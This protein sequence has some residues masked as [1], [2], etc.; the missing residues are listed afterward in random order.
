MRHK[1][2]VAAFLLLCAGS[3]FALTGFGESNT[4]GITEETLPVEMSS[5]SATLTANN[6]V[7]LNWVTQSETNLQG[8]YVY[9][10]T[11]A[12][13]SS[14]SIVSGLIQPTNTSSQQSYSFLDS[15]IYQSGQY[16]YWLYSMEMDGHGSFHGP[17]S[18][19]VNLDGG[20]PDIPGIPL[21][22]GLRAIYP[23]PFNPSTTISYH[24]AAEGVAKLD[25][26]NI[27]GQMVDTLVNE[28]KARGKHQV[29]WDGKDFEGR[30]VAS[31]IYFV[32]LSSAG[33][34]SSTHKMVLMK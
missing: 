9:R 7:Q 18:I 33:K 29:V 13:L 28:P 32:R 2:L 15:E 3:I 19:L 23:N 34:S 30:E 26:Y 6:Y 11:A 16:Y 1:L 5:F 22:T 21:E 20:N 17:A 4:F 12:N 14:A 24:L 10:C 8:Y 31:G 25:I 27:K